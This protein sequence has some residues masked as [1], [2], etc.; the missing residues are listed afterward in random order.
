LQRNKTTKLSSNRQTTIKQTAPIKAASEESFV[1]QLTPKAAV[2]S[3]NH[4]TTV[5]QPK[6][7]KPT[8]VNT[9]WPWNLLNHHAVNLASTK[10]SLIIRDAM[11]LF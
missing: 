8:M 1:V 2:L 11:A 4:Q 6:I 9:F 5:K 10:E 7:S 3:S